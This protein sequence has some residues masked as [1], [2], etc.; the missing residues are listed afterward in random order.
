MDLTAYWSAVRER[1]HELETDGYGEFVWVTSL[2]VPSHGIYA[3]QTR[4]VTRRSAAELLVKQTHRIASDAEVA[5]HQRKADEQRRIHEDA[6]ARRE[7]RVR[8]P[9]PDVIGERNNG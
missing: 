1:E 4:H 7:G 5:E 3:G 9:R 8:V 6:E 2:P